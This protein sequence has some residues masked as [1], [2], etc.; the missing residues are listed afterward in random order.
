MARVNVLRCSVVTPEKTVVET[1]AVALTFP[2]WDGM[3]GLLP[4]RAPLLVRLGAGL[5]TLRTRE[6]SA[7]Y[8]VD[9]GFLQ[10]REGVVTVLADRCLTRDSIDARQAEED[11]RRAQ[12]MPNRTEEEFEARQRALASARARLAL[13]RGS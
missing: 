5:L 11:L 12:A 13:A 6:G 3:M 10:V 2:A 8:F 9:G 4:N 1:E 7:E